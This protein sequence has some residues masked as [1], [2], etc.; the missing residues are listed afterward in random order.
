MA[1]VF[2]P[3][4]DDAVLS[5]ATRLMRGSAQ[6]VNVFAG[7]PPPRVEM[8]AWERLTRA[9]SSAER[10]RE[11]LAEDREAMTLLSCCAVYLDLPEKE[12]RERDIGD[13]CDRL[14]PFVASAREIWVP[15][16]IGGHPDHV[17][18]RDAVLAAHAG[19]DGEVVFYADLPYAVRYGWPSWAIRTAAPRFLAPDAWLNGELTRRGLD[20]AL[21]TPSVVTLDGDLRARKERAVRAYRTQLAALG[22]GPDQRDNWKTFLGHELAWRM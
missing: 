8:M 10:H 11:R 19:G 5:A 21:L 16:A 17:A 12:H 3:H 7:A 15:A 13:L 4:L 9:H 2:S 1:I 6:V 20:P 14:R 18:T 22:L